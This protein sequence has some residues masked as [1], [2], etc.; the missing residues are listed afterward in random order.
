MNCFEEW[1]YE[2][3]KM[4]ELADKFCDPD[5]Q[6]KLDPAR[7]HEEKLLRKKCLERLIELDKICKEEEK[8]NP[9]PRRAKRILF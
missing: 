8:R 1:E 9:D 3:Q 5:Y 4:T 7:K 6:R 2:K